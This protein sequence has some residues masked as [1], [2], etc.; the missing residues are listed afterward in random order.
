MSI[1]V[2]K[3]VI[4]IGIIKILCF[5]C[6]CVKVVLVV[7][8]IMMIIYRKLINGLFYLNRKWR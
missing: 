3:K 1:I 4:E 6:V 8:L 7:I 5:N 2:I